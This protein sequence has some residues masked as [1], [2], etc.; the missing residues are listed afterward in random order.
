MKYNVAKI[1]G[2]E[3]L[4]VAGGRYHLDHDIVTDHTVLSWVYDCPCGEQ[5]GYSIP[6]PDHATREQALHHVKIALM[7]MRRHVRSEGNEPNF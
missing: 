7:A 6:V 5:S 2:D 3:L 1:I 4:R